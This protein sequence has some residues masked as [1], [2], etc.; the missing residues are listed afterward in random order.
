MPV[1][2][3]RLIDELEAMDQRAIAVA[4]GL[5][6]EQ[7]NWKAA[8]DNWSVGQ[9]LEHLRVT[10]DVYLSPIAD[11]L[12]SR[13]RAPVHEITP[14]WLG[15]WFIRNYIEPS[16]ESRRARAPKKLAPG[17][18]IDPSILDAFLRSNEA[19]RDLIRRAGAHDVNRIR[20]RN[21]FV[22]LVRFTVGTGFEI[23]STHQ[24]RHLL[25]AERVRQALNFPE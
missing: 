13:P 23:V 17:E 11:A 20:F 14:G 2:S 1:W 3:V 7:L 12:E 19:A 6:P 18:R 10:N 24:R 21:P 4:R 9:C 22:P 8:D 15:R 25:Q 5:S 16:S